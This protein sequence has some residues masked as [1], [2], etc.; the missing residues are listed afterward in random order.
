MMDNRSYANE[1]A[2]K[3]ME[4][5]NKSSGGNNPDV[6]KSCELCKRNPEV[7]RM[8]P[9]HC[10]ECWLKKTHCSECFGYLLT[11]KNPCSDCVT[12]SNT[13]KC[14]R[15]ANC[16]QSTACQEKAIYPLSKPRLCDRHFK[17]NSN[18]YKL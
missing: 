6:I 9:T 12:S 8:N 7:P 16:N 18:K 17:E 15:F 13:K 2:E 11:P 14:S 5:N 3:L 4:Q 1:F 10:K